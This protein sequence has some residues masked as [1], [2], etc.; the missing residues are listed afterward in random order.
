ME[1]QAV[2]ALRFLPFL[3]AV[4]A[5]V[6]APFAFE[7]PFTAALLVAFSVGRDVVSS[8]EDVAAG[9]VGEVAAF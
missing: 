3:L 5:E 7:C 8:F 2:G 9:V 1:Y 6:A 4:S